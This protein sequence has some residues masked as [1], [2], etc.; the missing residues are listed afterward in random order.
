MILETERLLLRRPAAED[1]PAYAAIWGDPEVV[2][3]IGGETWDLQRAQDGIERMRRHWEW[4]DIGLFTVVRKRDERILGRVGFL[5]WNE[6][7]QNGHRERVEPVETEIGW[8][9]GRE[10]WNRGYATEAAAACRDQ[11]LGPLGLKRVISLIAAENTASIRVAEK[12]GETFEREIRGGFFRFPVG[13]C[14]LEAGSPA[15]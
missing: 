3:F 11:A 12:I 2:R 7:W 5:V 8:T 15:R 9:I 14:A 10:F 1:A 13:L 6:N 4:F